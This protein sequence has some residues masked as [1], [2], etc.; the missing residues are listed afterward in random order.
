MK[1]YI[2]NDAA[3]AQ[4]NVIRLLLMLVTMVPMELGL[5]DI[6][7]AYLQFGPI[8]RRLSVRPSKDWGPTV[9]GALWKLVKLPYGITEAGRQWAMVIDEYL[10]NH[11]KYERLF[12]VRRVFV[13]RDCDGKKCFR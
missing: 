6:K 2:R 9:K 4:F 12:R 3:T 1:G 7:G 10:L 13:N 5:I 11:M 8:R